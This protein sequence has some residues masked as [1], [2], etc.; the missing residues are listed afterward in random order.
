M[1]PQ[2][3]NSELDKNLVQ[4]LQSIQEEISGTEVKKDLLDAIHLEVFNHG[5][6]NLNA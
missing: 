4:T 1:N 5:S 6:T 2:R 3:K